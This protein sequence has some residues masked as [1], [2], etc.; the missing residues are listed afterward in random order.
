[1]IPQ[2]IPTTT[3]PL[4]EITVDYNR[5]TEYLNK[6]NWKKAMPLFLRCLKVMRFKEALINLGNCYKSAG[7]YSKMIACYKE[8][9]D[10]DTNTLDADVQKLTVQALTNLGLAYFSYG[11]EHAAIQYLTKA[12][13]LDDKA[14]S[15]WWNLSITNLRLASSGELD[16]FARGWEMYDSRFLKEPAIKLKNNKEN[17]V[18]WD[19]VSPGSS[20]IVL[21][22]QGIGDNIMWGRY[23]PCLREK[24]EKVYIQC[25]PS[26]NPIFSDYECVT[27]AIFSSAELAYPICS[28]AKCFNNGIPVAGDWLNGKFGTRSFP[29]DKFNV[30]IVWAGSTEH[31]NNANRSVSIGRFSRLA[32]YCN[33]Y[34]LSPNFSSTKY[35]KSLGIKTWTD[36]AECI[37]GLDLVIGVDTSV[38]HLCGSMGRPGWLLQ[39]RFETDFRWGKG[40]KSVWYS[41]I[42]VFQNNGW[43]EV[44][45]N[46][47]SS[48][49]ERLYE[50][51]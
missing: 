39:P 16:R 36:T 15:A 24:F 50:K 40:S 19:G 3:S 28:L 48:L 46:V 11:D 5:G 45:D 18:Y 17:L 1:M 41:S 9:V 7:E 32:K 42:E 6:G 21:A 43:E 35:V 26:L 4:Q 12:I 25:D 31:V 2:V 20:I 13:K 51:C 49:K 37:N 22:E 8:A 30:G 47:E 27:D 33:L 10:P 38:M 14:W 44:F 29:E 23:L 34:S